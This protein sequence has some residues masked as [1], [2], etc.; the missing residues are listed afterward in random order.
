MAPGASNRTI[1]DLVPEVIEALQNRTDVSKDLASRYL[2]RALQEVT[3]SNPFEELRRTGPTVSL[4]ANVAVYPVTKFL[5]TGDDYSSPESFVIYVDFPNNTIVDSIDYKT[6]KGIETMMA[7]AT[8]G[9][10]SRFTRY[11]TNFHFGPVPD[12][13][14][15]V[16]LRYQVKHPFPSDTT[17]L[18]GATLFI[19]DSWEEI[20]IYSAAERIAL[21]KRWNDQA[22]TLH[23]ILYGDP[24]FN[25][26]GGKQGR[27]GLLSARI[28]QA[29][30]DGRFNS[31]QFGIRVGRYNAR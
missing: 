19:P 31:R 2:R 21:V 9:V 29:E 5:N 14:Y 20:V 7:P 4:T 11:G 6:P 1:N 28:F 27:P 24:E 10:P 25:T 26:S 3:E 15:S 16:F 23:D 13:A 22:K 17:A 30:R 8:T 12:K 18:S